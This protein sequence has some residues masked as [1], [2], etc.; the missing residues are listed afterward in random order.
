MWFETYT[1]GTVGDHK[2]PR[3]NAT[4]QR[5]A[6]ILKIFP[7]VFTRLG[8]L[9]G[10]YIIRLKEDA[11]LFALYTPRSILFSLQ[12]QVQDELS[13]METLGV[14]SKVNDPTPWCAGMVVVP[15]KREQ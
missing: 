4:H 6:D 10:E 5:S 9:G 11:C 13:W 15:K 1:T 8:T 7:K 3:V 12:N 2:S 14:I